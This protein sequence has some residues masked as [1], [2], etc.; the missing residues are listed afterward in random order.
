MT[1]DAR[2]GDRPGSGSNLVFG[3]AVVAIVGGAFLTVLSLP[4]QSNHTIAAVQA[5]TAPPIHKPALD[6]T[7]AQLGQIDGAGAFLNAMAAI[8]ARAAHQ[9][10][11][12]FAQI[13]YPTVERQKLFLVSRGIETIDRHSAELAAIHD[14][15]IDALIE[16]TRDRLRA[17]SQKKNAKCDGGNYPA[18]TPGALINV[19][20]LDQAIT[21]IDAPLIDYK[22]SVMTHMFEAMAR[23]RFAPERRG[24]MTAADKAAWD[25]IAM[26]LMSDPQLRPLLTETTPRAEGMAALAGFDLCE[27]GATAMLAVKT[28]PQDTK[29]RLFAELVDAFELGGGQFADLSGL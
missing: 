28:L 14:N 17:A 16:V 10:K 27:Y 1:F 20:E 9:T 12:D 21:E 25:G 24:E 23:A 11:T 8:D 7:V 19:H 5:V 4:P 2:S 22:L 29:G 3:A 6:Q 13:T 26:S 15:D 18:L